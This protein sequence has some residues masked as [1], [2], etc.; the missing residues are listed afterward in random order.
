MVRKSWPLNSQI[1]DLFQRAEPMR[2][3][4]ETI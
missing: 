4:L 1:T 3:D 2:V